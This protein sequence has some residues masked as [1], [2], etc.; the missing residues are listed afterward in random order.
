MAKDSYILGRVLAHKN[1][2][3]DTVKEALKVYEQFRQPVA[4]DI[5]E[6][7]R[8]V[9]MIYDFNHPDFDGSGQEPS[10]ESLKER[11]QVLYRHWSKQWESTPEGDWNQAS[12][13]LDGL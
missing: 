6:R 2:N 7:S 9:G 10:L 12:R 11:S 3:L 13:I 5:L 1:T 8:T 4:S